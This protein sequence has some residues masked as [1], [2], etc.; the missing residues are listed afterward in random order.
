MFSVQARLLEV[1][2][3]TIQLFFLPRL[4]S[5][6]CRHL[7]LEALTLFLKSLPLLS[8]LLILYGANTGG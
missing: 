6:E 5:V 2:G 8:L 3:H 4:L 7:S 1:F